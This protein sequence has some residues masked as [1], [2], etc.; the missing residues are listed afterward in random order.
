MLL[1]LSLVVA[2]VLVLAGVFFLQDRL[3]YFP[4]RTTVAAL[5]TGGLKPWPGP[6]DF[7]GL[8]VEPQG[9]VRGTVVVFHGNGGHAGHRIRYVQVFVP[10][11][12]RVLLAEY[13]GYGPRGGRV[14][15]DSFVHDAEETV[16]LVL[17]QYGQPVVLLG[18]SLGAAVAAAAAQRHAQDIEGVLLMTPWDRLEHVARYH[19]PWLLPL[20]WMLRDQYDTVARL[21][22]LGRPV[23]VVVA[24]RDHIV[25]ARLG[26]A[27]HAALQ[28]PKHLLVIAEAQHNDWPSHV[29]AA[30]WPE[31]LALAVGDSH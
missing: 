10:L 27:L 3:L 8:V 28:E 11:G 4:G 24:E 7:R 17:R 13:P 1:L 16:S 5:A 23:V 22:H 25:P 14:G 26:V 18:E 31:V 12:W 30:W 20:R 9:A 19:Y 29:N 2:A 15:E 21:A 6:D